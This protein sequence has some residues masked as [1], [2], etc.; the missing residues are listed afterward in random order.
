MGASVGGYACDITRT[1]VV[2]G[3]LGA[4]DELRRV[5]DVV[6][7]ANEAGRQAARPGVEIQDVDRAARRVIAEAGYGA[8]FTHRTGHGLG[9]EGH[10]PPFA[11]QGDTTILEPGMT[12]TV[13]PGVYLPGQGGVRVED[14][15]V[16]TAD[17]CESLTTFDRELKAI[18][19]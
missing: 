11:C 13:E 7:R 15:V 10:E 18:G 4:N 14:D 8:Y 1:F 9:L 3:A 6:R 12:F 5:Y 16:I 19:G 17:G 2:G